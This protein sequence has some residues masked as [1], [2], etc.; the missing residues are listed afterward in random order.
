MILSL[1]P[2]NDAIKLL[3]VAT[4]RCQV[5]VTYRITPPK[6][7]QCTERTKIPLLS[8]ADPA[9]AGALYR[10]VPCESDLPNVAFSNV[11]LLH[12]V[13]GLQTILRRMVFKHSLY[14][15]TLNF[16]HAPTFG[17]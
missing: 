7:L 13:Q 11:L 10:L 1:L 6:A 17:P 12:A 9:G 8:L 2:V 15:I 14:L 3:I 16:L 5:L 4:G